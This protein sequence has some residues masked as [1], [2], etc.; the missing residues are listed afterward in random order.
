MKKRILLFLLACVLLHAMSWAGGKSETGKTAGPVTL[1][2]WHDQGEKG[3]NWFNDL[4]AL[5]Q[6]TNPGVKIESVTYPTQQWIEKSIAALNTNTAPDIIFNNYERVIKVEDQ[7]N[8]IFDLSD[9][10]RSLQEKD[11]LSEQ[12]LS[13]AKYKGKMLIFPIQRVQMAFG[14]RKSWLANT[15]KSFPKTWAE[16]LDLAETFTKGDPDKNGTAGDTFGLALQ[17]ANPRDLI[18]MLDLFTFGT[19]IRHTII[20]PQGNI[21]INEPRR[22]EITKAFVALYWNYTARD[23][24]NHS[25]TEMYQIIEGGKAGMF[26]VGDWNVNKWDRPDVLGGDYVIGPWPQFKTGDKNAVVIGG[27][28]GAAVPANSQKRDAAVKFVQ[29]LLTKEAQELSFK[30]IGSAVRKDLNLQLSEHQQFF[31]NPKYDLIAYDFPESIHPYYPQIEDMYHKALLK[32]LANRNIDLDALLV[33]TEKQMK[34]FIAS[35]KK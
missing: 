12:D 14:V 17:A 33:E 8:K 22:K 6:K 30:H 3:V 31:A 21:V 11:I 10:Y 25:F 15:G 1:M 9:A 27:M 26:R 20:D 2:V 4:N 13:V 28:R 24:I 23:T 32:A 16:M 18:H 19:G 34:D 29:F 5:Y 7:T 35:R